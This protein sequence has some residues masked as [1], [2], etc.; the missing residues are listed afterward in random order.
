MVPTRSNKLCPPWV[1]VLAKR[2]GGIFAARSGKGTS[3]AARHP[4]YA[5]AN[6]APIV[7]RKMFRYPSTAAAVGRMADSTPPGPVYA[8]TEDLYR[9]QIEKIARSHFNSI[10]K[11][12]LLQTV[13]QCPTRLR[14][15]CPKPGSMGRFRRNYLL[16]CAG[17]EV[18]PLPRTESRPAHKSEV[19]KKSRWTSAWQ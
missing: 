6:R 8:I 5:L 15:R 11:I 17:L 4:L 2:P 9:I 14:R 16:C 12:V 3:T 10:D 18:L 1:M 7:R 13:G 19:A